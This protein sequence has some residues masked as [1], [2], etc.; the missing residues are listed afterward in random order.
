M[1]SSVFAKRC[2]GTTN[3]IADTL[4]SLDDF[5]DDIAFSYEAN[6]EITANINYDLLDTEQKPLKLH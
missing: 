1:A 2:S 6:L 4:S 3:P 5:I